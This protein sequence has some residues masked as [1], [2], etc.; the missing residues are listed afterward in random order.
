MNFKELEL[1][2]ELMSAE[3]AVVSK[4]NIYVDG[5]RVQVSKILF[6]EKSI[7]MP[8]EKT[9]KIF[10]KTITHD[11]HFKNIFI[12]QPPCGINPLNEVC[13][14]ISTTNCTITDK[15]SFD[16]IDYTNAMIFKTNYPDKPYYAEAEYRLNGLFKK[17]TFELIQL[18]DI[19]YDTT[20]FWIMGEDEHT[21]EY[22]LKKMDKIQ[23]IELDVTDRQTAKIYFLCQNKSINYAVVNAFLQ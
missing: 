16:G 7:F 18:S 20:I 1:L 5:K 13:R 12:G 8:L 15:F 23:K 11:E 21:K 3:K 4:A 14:P 10:G 9:S 19:D 2:K 22:E 6:H 17:L